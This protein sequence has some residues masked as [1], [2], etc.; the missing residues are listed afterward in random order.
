[1]WIQNFNLLFKNS[2]IFNLISFLQIGSFDQKHY[3][4]FSLL[5]EPPKKIYYRLKLYYDRQKNSAQKQLLI[6]C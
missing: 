6:F 1:M 2:I 3:V 5:E 4:L